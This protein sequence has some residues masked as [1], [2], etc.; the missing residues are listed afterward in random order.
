[1]A[2]QTI[3]SETMQV[4]GIDVTIL[5]EG[6]LTVSVVVTD[7][8]GNASDAV[9]DT[10]TKRYDVAPTVVDDSFSTEEDTAKQF[11]LLANDSDVNDD[12]VASS[13]TIKTQPIKGQ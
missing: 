13:T 8:A 3:S 9:T 4:T 10:V 11:N 2:S 1:G 7:A 5:Q 12:M 6:T